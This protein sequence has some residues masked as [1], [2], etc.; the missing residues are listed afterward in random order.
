MPE[1]AEKQGSA[2]PPGAT[3][4]RATGAREGAA[5]GNGGSRVGLKTALVAAAVGTAV[6]AAA[7]A[8]GS[9]AESDA[10]SAA[11]DAGTPESLTARARGAV[12]RSEPVLSAAWDAA[13]GSIEPVAR[14]RARQAGRFLADLSPDFV[15]DNVIPPFVEGLTEAR[16]D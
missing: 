7:S 8:R 10:G 2:T 1:N 12:R 14:D 16:A 3:K 11:T 9:S 13:K 15:R 4:P 6:A 5:N